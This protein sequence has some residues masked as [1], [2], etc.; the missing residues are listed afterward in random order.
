M[1]REDNW[2]SDVKAEDGFRWAF[3]AICVMMAAISLF[4][5]P[6]PLVVEV[7]M[8][9]HI[10]VIVLLLVSAPACAFGQVAD[11]SRDRISITELTMAWRFHT[12]DDIRW[13]DPDF[14]DSSWSL[15]KPTESWADQGYKNYS[16]M[17]W[18][19]L[20]VIMPAGQGNLA[21]LIPWANSSYS[22]FANGQLIRQIGGLPPKP[23][24]VLAPRELFLIPRQIVAPSQSLVIALRFWFSPLLNGYWVA[25][26]V[27]PPVLGDALA[28]V[29]WR[30]LQIHDRFWQVAESAVMLASN[31]LSALLA[32]V[33]FAFRR[34]EREYLWYGVAQAFWLLEFIAFVAIFF[35]R[36]PVV[37]FLFANYFGYCVGSLLNLVFLHVLL[38]ERPRKFYWIA[39]LPM[40]LPVPAFCFVLAGWTRIAVM[41]DVLTIGS[42]SYAAALVLLL[43][44]SVLNRKS[45]AWVLVVPYTFDSLYSIYVAGLSLLDMSRH[46]S[47]AA[48]DD[49]LNHLITWPFTVGLN[50][51]DGHICIASVCA[52]LILRFARSRREEERLEAELEAART[53]QQVL[54]PSEIP[55]IPGFQVDAVYR[56]ASQVGGDFFQVVST[57][58][59]GG[60]L[61]VIGDVSGKGMPAAMTVS[62]LVGTFRTLAHYTQ[63]PGEILDAMNRRMLARSKGGFT[64]C[65]VVRIDPDGMLTAANA[66][67]LAPYVNGTEMSLQNGLPLGIDAATS[68]TGSKFHLACDDQLTL[69]T[70]GVIEARNKTGELYG[71]ERASAIARKS[72]ESIARTAQDF[73]QADDITVVTIVRLS[74]EETANLPLATA[75]LSGMP[76]TC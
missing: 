68:Y 29:R 13:A 65:L 76:E 9:L 69:V 49:H 73:G 45:E 32:F 57:E 59:L 19:R 41:D 52:V 54:I 47:I 7:D 4:C 20:R 23:R 10:P 15:L 8:R 36:I 46:P 22:V 6:G 18:Y 60:A 67:H 74:V 35:L 72:A 16:G 26:L 34:S 37:P 64:T 31:F 43:W 70:D 44:H 48:F 61:I 55:I 56:P 25:G 38:H 66:G 28:V 51:I 12:G 53:V 63:L 75:S 1:L 33:L 24:A 5:R 30:D 14:D 62:L 17:A 42:V 40:L 2:S 21:I 39:A 71:F 27:Q 50:T 58:T 3:A 11:L